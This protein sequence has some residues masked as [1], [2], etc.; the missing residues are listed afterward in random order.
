MKRVLYHHLV[1]CALQDLVA[2]LIINFNLYDILRL[3]EIL[4]IWC[5]LDLG[6]GDHNINNPYT[7]LNVNSWFLLPNEWDI[8]S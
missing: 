4:K 5:R 2:L 8:Y 3:M 6:Y 1:S 7:R